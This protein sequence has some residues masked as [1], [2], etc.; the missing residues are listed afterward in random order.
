MVIKNMATT[1]I[2][3]NNKNYQAGIIQKLL[4]KINIVSIRQEMRKS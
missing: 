2:K 3:R 4:K 1:T